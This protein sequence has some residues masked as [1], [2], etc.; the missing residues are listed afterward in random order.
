M[1]P[2]LPIQKA[3]LCLHLT[4]P[5]C[6]LSHTSHWLVAILSVYQHFHLLASKTLTDLL[7]FSP[8]NT[9]HSF[10]GSFTGF[11]S[12]P[13][14][15]NVAPPHLQFCPESVSFHPSSSPRFWYTPWLSLNWDMC[16]ELLTPMSIYLPFLPIWISDWCFLKLHVLKMFVLSPKPKLPPALTSSVNGITKSS[17]L[18]P[19]V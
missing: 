9:G 5:L 15:P 6:S 7:W 8:S 3:V 1:S 12:S 13:S 14:F 18:K 4:W 10:L 17:L 16:P 2:M 11:S 19:K